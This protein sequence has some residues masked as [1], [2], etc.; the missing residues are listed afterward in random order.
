MSEEITNNVEAAPVEAAPTETPAPPVQGSPEYNQEMAAIGQANQDV[1]NNNVPEKFRQEDGSVDIAGMA[2]SYAELEKQFHN[3]TAQPETPAAEAPVEPPKD[4]QEFRIPTPTEVI[5]EQT[6]PPPSVVSDE[7]Y[8]N[9]SKELV[10][11][12]ELT[13][14]TRESIKQKTGFNDAMINDF[15][16]AQ[17]AK[18]KE[19]FGVA[20][21]T[22]GGTERL[23]GMLE[24]AA[25][26]LPK[27]KQMVLNER[28]AG[29]DYDITLQGIAAMYDKAMANAPRAQEPV[30]QPNQ[31]PNPAGRP[32]VEGF[33]SYGEFTQARS[34]PRYMQDAKYRSA[35]EERM[36]K[37]NWQSLPR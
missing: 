34:D 22:V 12:G 1:L 36:V 31:V 9:W 10:S 5:E 32:V 16:F 14:E 37:T 29:P 11:V 33:A 3:Q 21:Q 35:V 24:W 7:D 25:N 4:Q 2:K 23:S 26:N 8:S 28:L 6:A 17:K 20:A 15:V 27:E 30:P 18:Q 19:A 13:P